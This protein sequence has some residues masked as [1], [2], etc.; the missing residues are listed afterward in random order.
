[1][2]QEDFDPELTDLGTAS[3]DT[4]GA[5]GETVEAVGLWHKTG[6]SDE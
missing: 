1:M 3:A 6:I 2:E 4:K 5:M